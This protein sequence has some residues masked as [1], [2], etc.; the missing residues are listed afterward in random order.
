MR[1]GKIALRVLL[2]LLLSAV[3]QV[4]AIAVAARVHWLQWLVVLELPGI[5]LGILMNSVLPKPSCTD[6]S[7]FCGLGQTLLVSAL[8]DWLFWAAVLFIFQTV[9]QKRK[10]ARLQSEN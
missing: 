3:V 5:C 10:D 4:S 1:K 6:G 7:W 9:S 8:T 2:S